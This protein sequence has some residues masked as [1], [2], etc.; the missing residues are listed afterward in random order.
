[1]TSQSKPAPHGPSEKTE[2][3]IGEVLAEKYRLVF[4]IDQGGMSTVYVAED[5]HSGEEVAVKIMRKD[6][7]WNDKVSVRFMYEAMA[8]K[9]IDH[10][11]II[12][13][14]ETGE[15]PLDQI[16]LAMEYIRGQSLRR[17]IQNGPVPVKTAL[18]LAAAIAEG[19][20][21]AHARGVIHRDLKPENVLIPR[22]EAQGA[23]VKLVDFG[24]ARIIDAPRLTTTQ[25]VMGTPQYISPEQALGEAV[26]GRADIYALGVLL[27]E[28]LTGNLPFTGQ[29]PEFLLRQHISVP[30]P[31]L[32]GCFA[33][34]PEFSRELGQLIMQCLAKDPDDRPLDMYQVLE[35]LGELQKKLASC[36]H[37]EP[38]L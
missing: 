26:D 2:N 16:F 37:L 18:A 36:Q 4:E 1:M 23:L 29:D 25:H 10:P 20:C 6:L 33:D 27:F 11:A 3:L 7:A 22:R 13:I 34:N 14:Y 32:E 8:V 21:A 24:I 17:V 38:P 5:I 12:K 35:M 15:T 28:M 9:R 19:L 31:S 30:P